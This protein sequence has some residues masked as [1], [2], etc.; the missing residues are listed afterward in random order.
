VEPD[1]AAAE[2][3]QDRRRELVEARAQKPGIPA[4]RTD[5]RASKTDNGVP[6]IVSPF[7]ESELIEDL[8][9]F[10]EGV[11]SEQQT[12]KRHQLTENDWVALAEDESLLRKIDD[13]KLRRI[14]DCST[15]RELA[16]LHVV[17]G[18]QVLA[19]IMDD[20]ATHAKHKIDSIKA[21]DQLATLPG[22]AAA[23]DASRFLIQINIGG[24]VETLQ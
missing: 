1:H 12:R 15:K 23:A 8:C 21:L 2:C 13:R 6:A 5:A 16:Q 19:T 7:D 22:Q 9:R 20:P 11:L 3:H 10:S 14:R 4:N 24:D 18:P 17:R